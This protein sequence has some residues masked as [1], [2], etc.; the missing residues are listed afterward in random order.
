M[1]TKARLFAKKV[2]HTK[3]RAVR[4]AIRGRRPAHKRVLLHPISLFG[5]LCVGVLLANITWHSLA[6]TIHT[7][8]K[9]Q[10]PALTD[11]AV[12]TSPADG[13][14]VSSAPITVSGTC[15]ADSYVKL[16]R[17]NLFSGVATCD[18]GTFSIQT[19]LFVG[20]NKLEAQDYNV[21]DDP[22]PAGTPIFVTYTPPSP[23]PGTT[24]TPQPGGSNSG[25]EAAG[26]P[27]LL[28]AT[29]K[30]QVFQ[31]GAEVRWDVGI[32]GG[33]APYVV[34]VDWGDG[35]AKTQLRP[36]SEQTFVIRPSYSKA[37]HYIIKV[38]ARDSKESRAMLQLVTIIRGSP[39]PVAS[40]TSTGGAG[41]S[42][43][44]KWLWLIGPAYGVVLLMAVSFLLGEWQEYRRLL[45]GRRASP[46]R[47]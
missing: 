21:T 32:S 34:L 6:A 37:G 1:K 9:V 47:A 17:N 20:V 46:R 22:G 25:H 10:A 41:P 31:V 19:D 15:P 14:T 12:I 38:S 43:I 24:P 29:Y 13:T 16:F 35:T 18:S 26:N 8:A 36:G 23:P 45:R 30:Y 3:A 2:S 11:P 27:L 7:T 28:N 5:L 4:R 33:V 44:Q 42:F 40:G 39:L